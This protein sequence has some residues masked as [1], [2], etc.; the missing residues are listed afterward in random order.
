MRQERE[1]AEGLVRTHEYK[2]QLERKRQR[3]VEAERQVLLAQGWIAIGRYGHMVSPLTAVA[4]YLFG[5]PGTIYVQKPCAQ[6]IYSL[7]DP[8]TGA[9][10]YI[11]RTAQPGERLRHHTYEAA[12]TWIQ[13][14]RDL[15]L[16][17]EIQLL[18][19]I[20][21]QRVRSPYL[22]V[23][24]QF[25]VAGMTKTAVSYQIHVNERE[26]RWILYG[27][28]QGWDLSNNEARYP[29]LREIAQS[30]PFSILTEPLDSLAWRP[31]LTMI[32]RLEQQREEL[33]HLRS[34]EQ[35]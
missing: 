8:R 2:E 10:R 27:L 17:A 18:E 32:A 33:L 9:Y 14:L 28:Q 5:L 26:D 22:A 31:Y 20:A 24:P 30:L 6:Y 15:G 3:Q 25:T 16:S 29:Y 7:V 1:S 21:P 11:G 13:E 34:T 4:N 23:H 35:S 12:W 19:T